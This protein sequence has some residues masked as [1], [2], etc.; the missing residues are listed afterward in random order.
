MKIEKIEQMEIEKMDFFLIFFKSKYFH[1]LNIA[2]KKN[3]FI[4]IK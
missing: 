2:I 1:N 3:K 4:F